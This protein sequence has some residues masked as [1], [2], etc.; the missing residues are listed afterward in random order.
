MS[1][2]IKNPPI[3]KE[4]IDHHGLKQEEYDLIVELIG[5]HPNLT[6]LGMFS[7]MWSEHCCYKSSKPLITQFPT[8]G[9][10]VVCGPGENAGVIDVG[11]NIFVA[12]KVESHNHPTAVEPFQ[13]AATG[14]GGILRDIFTMNARPIANFNSLRFGELDDKMN[15]F[16]FSGAVAGIAFYGNCVGVP[17]LGGECFFDNSFSGNPLVN[18]MTVGV[19]YNKEIIKS[20]AKGPGNTVMYVGSKT[21]KDGLAG[22]AFASKEITEESN[23]DRPAVQVG[24]P[25]T[26][27]Q[28]I[29]ACLEAFDTKK[30]IACQDMGAAGLTCSISEM[31]NNGDVGIILDLDKVPVRTENITPYEMM[32]SESQERMLLICEPQDAE[33]IRGIFEKWGLSA[34]NVGQVTEDERLV[35]LYK[36]EEVVNI[37]AYSITRHAPVYNHKAETPE[38]LQKTKA[39]KA[40]QLKD[41][42][43]NQIE[44][45]LENLL[46][47]TNICSRD[48]V[49]NQ[50]DRQVQNNSILQSEQQTGA[51]IRLRDKEG[52]FLKRGVS[53]SLD[54]N[55]RYTY[56][57]PY[58]GARLALAESAR[59]VAVTGAKPIAIT[60]N[61]NFANPEKPQMFWQLSEACRGIK[62]GCH[63]LNV[64]V[65]GG[66]VSLY[67]ET[68]GIPIYPT[69][70]IGMV[71]LIDDVSKAMSPGFKQAGD[72]VI[73]VGNNDVDL[74]GS[75]Y[76]KVTQ[77][78]Q[79][80]DIPDA[81]FDHEKNL[82]Q[83]CIEASQNELLQSCCDLAE[84]GLLVTVTEAAIKGKLGV[85]L[86]EKTT[87]LTSRLDASLFGETPG[88][89]LISTTSQNQEKVI[90]LL[91]NNNLT[92]N[93]IGTVQENK[94][95]IENTQLSITTKKVKEIWETTLA[96]TMKG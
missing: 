64:C 69:P 25:F 7:V 13:G 9:E 80:G 49:F 41:L 46:A 71:G 1:T 57:D 56:L 58:K 19:L 20:G 3:A 89:L 27:K 39:W 10:K 38:Y 6:E 70:V 36:D 2:M 68:N 5:K 12:F 60:N 79:T 53:V 85:K 51:V 87:K 11:D 26:G 59:N 14:V 77:N 50:Y 16:L 31:A 90:E 74:G 4:V 21:G 67:N 55:S 81:D 28:L 44:Q 34:V 17:T 73:L 92:Y 91:K 75:E 29:E 32:L 82:H 18:A 72:T 33:E 83:F 54:C 93:I 96:T 24:D 40:D 94:I 63:E 76:L 88:R 52:N 65:T 45:T 8:K 78:L 62:D 47:S 23:K 86:T 43:V 42:Q 35:V 66:N 15:R 61:L 22:A 48:W 84:G 95:E 30:V 37:P